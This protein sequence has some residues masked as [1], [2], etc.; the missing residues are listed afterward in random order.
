MKH[1]SSRH[2]I[3]K[4]GFKL[5]RR[6][7]IKSIAGGIKADYLG[8]NIRLGTSV[9]YSDGYKSPY[10]GDLLVNFHVVVKIGGNELE[11]QGNLM[12][13]IND[14]IYPKLCPS[15]FCVSP[16]SNGRYAMILER[17]MN[18]S[19]LYSII[20]E[21]KHKYNVQELANSLFR[22][23]EK[24]YSKSSSNCAEKKDYISMYVKRM[25][26]KLKEA[27]KGKY[28]YLLR[29][30]KIIINDQNVTHPD[31]ILGF[32]E[33]FAQKYRFF[34]FQN[35]IHGDP[36]LGNIMV[37]KLKRGYS[38]KLID[39]NPTWG[40]C[41]YLYDIGK[42]YHWAEELGYINYEDRVRKHE[43]RKAIKARGF[44]SNDTLH[45]TWRLLL[46][47]EVITAERRRKQFLDV[48]N[49]WT[50]QMA[51]IVKDRNVDWRLDL[52]IAS[53]HAGMLPIVRRKSHF[54]LTYAKMIE[55]LELAF[56]CLKSKRREKHINNKKIFRRIRLGKQFES[57]VIDDW[58][59]SLQKAAEKKLKPQKYITKSS[60]KKGFIDIYVSESDT[61]GVV[62]EC[63]HSDWD[64][65][66]DERLKRNIS[67][68]ISQILDYID[69]I[70]AEGK[71]VTPGVV[72]PKMPKDKKRKKY[73]EQKFSEKCITVVWQDE[74]RPMG[75][76]EFNKE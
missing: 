74:S 47:K 67:R 42:I 8:D 52:S 24:Y 59:S 1:K 13:Q 26:E 20:Y 55:H 27:R 12:Q 3:D 68:Q 58:T 17:L 31:I 49:W 44:C 37:R 69:S 66:T 22:R 5:I 10:V 65:M 2:W 16:I 36:H 72:F 11:Q 61:Y 9:P 56:Q 32:L 34:R 62:I 4:Q 71:E 46:Y 70:L 54:L 38:F 39:P 33:S 28:G 51:N 6:A 75:S 30:H 43:K 60:G 29:F 7:I 73:I 15:V 50:N 57:V 63:K 53:A 45:I 14:L 76:K 40:K 19:S 21:G 64:S 41:D 25:C 18:F 48:L 35:L 23:L